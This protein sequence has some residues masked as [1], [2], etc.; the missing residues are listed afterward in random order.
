MLPVPFDIL[1][2]TRRETAA[3]SAAA[4]ETTGLPVLGEFNN[5]VPREGEHQEFFSRGK[6]RS[7]EHFGDPQAE[8]SIDYHNFAAGNKPSIK[9]QVGGILNFAV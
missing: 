8:V 7:G 5:T 6:L 3:L 4:V 2:H 9:K 1:R